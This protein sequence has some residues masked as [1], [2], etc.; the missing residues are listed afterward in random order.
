MGLSL[1]TRYTLFME[2][3]EYISSGDGVIR[4]SNPMVVRDMYYDS[5]SLIRGF[6]DI[7]NS[8][9]DSLPTDE[10][11]RIFES[12]TRDIRN[13]LFVDR[14]TELIQNQVNEK[15]GKE[16]LSTLPFKTY[17]R[18][19]IKAIAD[20]QE[21]II[22]DNFI[23]LP[24]LEVV[25]TSRKQTFLSYA[26][27]DKGLTQALFIYFWMRAGFL[28]VNWMWDG[29]NNH[30]SLTKGK[31]ERALADSDQFLFLRTTNS[32]L[33]VR[34][35]NNSV[36]QWCAWEIGNYYTKH[37]DEKYYTSFYDRTEPR[38]DILDTFRP[39]KEVVLGEIKC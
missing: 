1:L 23:R 32:E 18:Y 11:Q 22:K 12:N 39:M 7:V 8:G 33:R 36:R 2:S 13:Q 15:K 30:S 24:E 19:L 26:Y 20:Y 29:V 34:G 10:Y 16:Q 35:N 27:Y 3:G 17:F 14:I 37:K 9:N 28:Y 6:E 38:N 25:R 5:A 21:E 31:L 4:L